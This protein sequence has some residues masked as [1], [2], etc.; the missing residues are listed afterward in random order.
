MWLR[1]YATNGQVAGST[2]DGV[3]GIFQWHNPSSRTMALG[4]TQPL[5][6]MST[7]FISCGKGCRCFRLTTF[8]PSCAVVMISGK[9]NFLEISEPLQ[10]CNGTALPCL[11]LHSESWK[12]HQYDSPKRSYSSTRLHC[13]T[14]QTTQCMCPWVSHGHVLLVAKYGQTAVG[15]T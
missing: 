11:Y 6:E 1:H 4:S 10:A 9:L 12:T 13:V 14:R 3:I 7:R 15:D 5:T 2:P 8:T